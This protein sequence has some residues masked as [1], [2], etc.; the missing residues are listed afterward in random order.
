MIGKWFMALGLLFTASLAGAQPVSSAEPAIV[1]EARSFMAAYAEDLRAGDRTAIAGRYSRGGAYMLGWNLKR[2]EDPA[3]IAASYAGPNW[4][5]PHSFSWA[6]LSYEPLSA[7]SII[8][9]GGFLWGI[10]DKSAPLTITYTALLRREAGGLKIRLEHE[11]LI[12]KPPSPT[13]PP[14]PPTPAPSG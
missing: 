4:Q 2:F 13:P 1:A 6:D 14:A 5:K 8:V 11:N 9:V 7:D 3:A 12:G 10:E